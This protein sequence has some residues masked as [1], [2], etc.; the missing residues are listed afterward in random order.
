VVGISTC[1]PNLLRRMKLELLF[2][3]CHIRQD[4]YAR[5]EEILVY[6]PEG[7]AAETDFVIRLQNLEGSIYGE[8]NRHKRMET[9]HSFGYPYQIPDGSYHLQF[10]PA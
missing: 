8:L 2:E 5:E 7:P 3:A 6:L 4:V 9:Q 1:A 10:M